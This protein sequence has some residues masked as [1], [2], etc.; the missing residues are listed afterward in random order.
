MT[1]ENYPV[2]GAYYIASRQTGEDVVPI[3]LVNSCAD[4]V[5]LQLSYFQCHSDSKQIF[6][7][8]H[9]KIVQIGRE[10][11]VVVL[12]K[13]VGVHG[14]SSPLQKKRTPTCYSVHSM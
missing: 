3:L 14:V 12:Q 11:W 2:E 13:T 10:G 8:A 9:L 7:T 5:S 6:K 4:D 1:K